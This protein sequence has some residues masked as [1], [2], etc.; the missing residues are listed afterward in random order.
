MTNEMHL[1]HTH[2]H[3]R[4]TFAIWVIDYTIPNIGFSP[5]SLKFS[6][7]SARNQLYFDWVDERA[8]NCENADCIKSVVMQ[9]RWQI[10][11]YKYPNFSICGQY[12]NCVY[13]A[14]TDRV[15]IE[16]CFVYIAYI[17]CQLVKPTNYQIKTI[18][19]SHLD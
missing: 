6:E 12:N 14:G 2:I 7:Q 18:I 19:L 9:C 8:G 1:N 16:W 17:Q 15:W 11:T 4:S 3:V 10:S 13:W 5:F